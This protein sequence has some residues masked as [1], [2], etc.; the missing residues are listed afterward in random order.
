M[1]AYLKQNTPA[2]QILFKKQKKLEIEF[3]KKFLLIH[4]IDFKWSL[5]PFFIFSIKRRQYSSR[6]NLFYLKN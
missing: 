1:Q 4:Q 6:C 2:E 5:V 3:H